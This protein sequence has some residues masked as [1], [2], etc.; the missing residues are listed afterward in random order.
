M[1]ADDFET[2]FEQYGFEVSRYDGVEADEAA[3]DED[4]CNSDA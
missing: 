3:A 2:L 4:S 1:D